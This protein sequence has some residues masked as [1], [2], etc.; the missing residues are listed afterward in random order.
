VS[1]LSSGY[2]SDLQACPQG[3]TTRPFVS[4]DATTAF[5][6]LMSQAEKTFASIMG[7]F[8]EP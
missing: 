3:L 2:G 5:A 1:R 4:K 7:T 6:D 8:K